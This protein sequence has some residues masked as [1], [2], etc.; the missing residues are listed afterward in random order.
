MPPRG[1]GEDANASVPLYD[2]LIM[3]PRI[4]GYS[5]VSGGSIGLVMLPI[6]YIGWFLLHNSSR[7]LGKDRPVGR[8][9]LI[10]NTLLGLALLVTLA[11][12]AYTLTQRF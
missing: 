2:V 7:F 4:L 5:T 9:A 6:A 1:E 11:S 3:S 12:V 10:W 8:S